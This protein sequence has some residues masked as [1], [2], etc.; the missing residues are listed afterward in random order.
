MS[1]K[2]KANVT[3]YARPVELGDLF[4][5]PALGCT[6][7]I[8]RLPS[9]KVSMSNLNGECWSE[10]FVAILDLMAH[11]GGRLIPFKPGESVT[12]TQE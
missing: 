4:A 6:H 10:A 9:G 8:R 2:V 1:V 3:S 7:Q 5:D 12:L 11:L